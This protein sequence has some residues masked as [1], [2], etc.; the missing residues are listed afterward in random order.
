MAER[1]SSEQL[2]RREIDKLKPE[3]ATN[4]KNEEKA[5]GIKTDR[6]AFSRDKIKV[7]DRW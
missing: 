5:W 1:K 6:A 2:E 3:V 4:D 7:P